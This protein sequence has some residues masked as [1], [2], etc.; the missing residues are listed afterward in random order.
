VSGRGAEMG[1]ARLIFSIVELESLVMKVLEGLKAIE[2][3]KSVPVPEL[4]LPV[5]GATGLLLVFW[6]GT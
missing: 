2:P 3:G 4:G 6:K 1:R 5:S